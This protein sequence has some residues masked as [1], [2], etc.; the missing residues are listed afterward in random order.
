MCCSSKPKPSL[1]I[2]LVVIN[3]L[4][5]SAT[6]VL[7]FILT[8]PGDECL[9]F[10]SVRGHALIY[11]NPVGCNYVSYGHCFLIASAIFL[12]IYVSRS[13]KGD[14]S[15]RGQ[16]Q[17]SVRFPRISSSFAIGFALFIFFFSL[18]ISAVSLAGYLTS[19]NELHYEAKNQLYA[20]LTIG[21]PYRFL[22]MSCSS[23][24][25][26]DDFHNRFHHDH[27]EYSGMFYGQNRGYKHG[28]VHN[29]VQDH[30][31]LLP[32]QIALEGSLA[33]SFFSWFIWLIISIFMFLNRTKKPSFDEFTDVYGNQVPHILNEDVTQITQIPQ[34][35]II[36]HEQQ[37]QQQQNPYFHQSIPSVMYSTLQPQLLNQNITPGLYIPQQ[38]T[39]LM[40]RSVTPVFYQQQKQ[41][42]QQQQDPLMNQNMQPEMYNEQYT[43]SMS[44]ASTLPLQSELVQNLNL[45]NHAGIKC[46]QL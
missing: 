6:S 19:C 36:Y 38:Q 11:G 17:I 14:E 8:Y 31:H 43:S 44:A 4:V 33:A 18:L 29:V 40:N 25:S 32:L 34:D 3:I 23:L 24:F 26:D 45:F 2:T 27:Y 37:L 21:N 39:P 16:S 1:I 12:L 7:M 30:E 13:N 22:Q 28:R 35:E 10:T 42:I 46:S 5:S 20:R 15:T 41:Q 9:L